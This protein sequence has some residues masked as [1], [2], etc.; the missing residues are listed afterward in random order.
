[1]DEKAKILVVDDD[2]DYLESVGA[3]LT[4]AR[5][6]VALAADEE[7]A[8]REIEA[9][10][11]DLIILDVMMSRLNSGFQFLWEL[12]RSEKHSGIPVLMVT[13]VDKALRLN[14]AR[15]ANARIRTAEEEA[16]LPVAGYIVKPVTPKRLTD[17]VES[18]LQRVWHKSAG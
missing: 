11:P 9:A 8:A 12:K 14:Y 6:Q 2:P 18:I 5:Y 15:H 10:R 1:M 17:T 3:M 7:Q 16:L 4:A 13:G